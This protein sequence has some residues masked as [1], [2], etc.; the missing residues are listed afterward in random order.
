MHKQ[1]GAAPKRAAKKA[2]KK[3]IQKKRTSKKSTLKTTTKR[4]MAT[5]PGY[6]PNMPAPSPESIS[7]QQHSRDISQLQTYEDLKL[8]S[9]ILSPNTYVPQ[10]ILSGDL[11]QAQ[12]HTRSFYRKILRMLPA[13]TTQYSMQELNPRALVPVIRS[14]FEKHG[15]VTSPQVMDSL[16]WE[17]EIEFAD[18]VRMF[19]TQTNTFST[20]FPDLHFAMLPKL[21]AAAAPK[22]YDPVVSNLEQ[23]ST[24]F[25]EAFLDP[26]TTQRQLRSER[27]VPYH[28]V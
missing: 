7:A 8:S 27:A 25:L 11:A 20:L 9:R 13:L 6:S 22:G 12:T 21:P 1:Q 10:M 24:P 17:A 26:M 4:T 16:R 2:P 28:H 14:H 15:K 18:I 19:Y 23:N 5:I 3:A